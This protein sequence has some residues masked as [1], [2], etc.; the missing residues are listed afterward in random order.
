MDYYPKDLSRY[1]STHEK[2]S[3]KTIIHLTRKLNVALN[4]LKSCE[5]IHLDLKPENILIDAEHKPY[6]SD[7][8]HSVSFGEQ[9]GKF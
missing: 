1:I 7:F 8:G 9:F 6:L 3:L 5:I 4:V 2:V